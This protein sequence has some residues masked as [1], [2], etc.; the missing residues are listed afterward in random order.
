MR[1]LSMPYTRQR[2]KVEETTFDEK[3]AENFPS[4]LTTTRQY[5]HPRCLT[6]R[7]KIPT[8]AP[9]DTYTKSQNQGETLQGNNFFLKNE[10]PN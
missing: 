2:R 9:S 3:N 4:S 10:S 8:K 6:S 1:I 7:K 5:T